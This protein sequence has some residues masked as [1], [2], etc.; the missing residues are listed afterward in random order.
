MN[1]DP[2]RKTLLCPHCGFS[3]T[4]IEAVDPNPS[5]V[6]LTVR[7]ENGHEFSVTFTQHKGETFVDEVA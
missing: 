2:D 3:Y 5:N 7:C 1:L 6:V 4:H